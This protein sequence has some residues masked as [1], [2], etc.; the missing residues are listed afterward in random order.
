MS[1]WNARAGGMSDRL[2]RLR[3]IAE[4]S[5]FAGERDAAAR[6]A[7]RLA[8]RSAPA[9]DPDMAASA[10]AFLNDLYDDPGHWT[11]TEEGRWTAMPSPNSWGIEPSPIVLS[12]DAMVRQARH[13]GGAM[14]EEW[15]KKPAGQ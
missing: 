10:A 14:F 2:A 15:L 9:I 6:L 5:H 3:R 12:D 11:R 13:E 7:A 4:T 8:S 1:S